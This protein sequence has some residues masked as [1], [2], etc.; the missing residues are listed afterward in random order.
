MGGDFHDL[1]PRIPVG[2]FLGKVH[3][4]NPGSYPD[5]LGDLSYNDYLILS[6]SLCFPLSA[7]AV[8]TEGPVTDDGVAELL[9]H[10]HPIAGEWTVL[11]SEDYIVAPPFLDDR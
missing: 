11:M 1:F 7:G 10:H 6:V 4:A 3:R 5:L 9:A 2:D 8:I